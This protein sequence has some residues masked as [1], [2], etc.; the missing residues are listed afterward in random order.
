MLQTTWYLLLTVAFAATFI[1]VTR[2][3]DE[4]L[5]G[6]VATVLWGLAAVGSF[7]IE[8]TRTVESSINTTFDNATG[9]VTIQRNAGEVVTEASAS[10]EVGFLA[11]TLALL[12]LAFTLAASTGQLPAREATRF[13][14]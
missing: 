11:A 12:M 10:P 9:N 7:E 3:I 8:Q 6:A 14:S 2:R 4:R 13:N 5:G 1:S